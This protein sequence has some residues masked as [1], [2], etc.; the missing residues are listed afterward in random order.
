MMG[1][2]SFFN[3]FL[4]ESGAERESVRGGPDEDSGRRFATQAAADR[5]GSAAVEGEAGHF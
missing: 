2:L 5:G 1:V 3:L 4:Q